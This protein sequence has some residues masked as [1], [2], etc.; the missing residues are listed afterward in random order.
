MFRELVVAAAVVLSVGFTPNKALPRDPLGEAAQ[1]Q[2]DRNGART[3][4]MIQSGTASTT[5]SEFQ[6]NNTNGP[7]Y[8]IDLEYDLSVQFYGRQKG[9]EKLLFPQEFF[10][11]A[12]ME[13]LRGTGYYESP[14]FKLRHQG[15]G[16]ARTLDG[17]VYPN[18]DKILMYDVVFPDSKGFEALIYAAAGIDPNSDSKP[19]IENLKINAYLFHGIPALGAVKLDIS[20]VVQGMNIKIGFD[21]KR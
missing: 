1:Y 13:Q 17:G 9:L 20:G 7:S 3:T 4:S 18:C 19:G 8:R 2:L 16:D 12:F 14:N 11:E 21:Y 5:V 10:D 15:M 6:P